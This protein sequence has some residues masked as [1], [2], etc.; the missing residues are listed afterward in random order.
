MF[1][2][3]SLL[4]LSPLAIV[5][6]A[7]ALFRQVSRLSLPEPGGVMTCSIRE[8]IGPLNPLASMGGVTRE[9]R[10]LV[11]EPLLVRDDDL[12]LRPNILSEWTEQTVVTVRCASEESAGETEAK[13][14]SGEVLPEDTR[15]LA[16]DRDGKVLTVAL[17]GF[18]SGLV[19][20]LL[21]RIGDEHLGRYLLV[22]VHLN[23][24]AADSIGSFL[25][26]SVER[27]QVKMMDFDGDQVA[28][29]FLQGDTDL[30]LRELEL[31]YE[32]NRSLDPEIRIVGNRCHTFSRELSLRLR[33]DVR[34]HDGVPVTTRDLLFSYEELTRP[35]SPLPL[36]GS[37][38]FVDTIEAVDDVRVRVACRDPA[39]VM[40]ESWEKL[41]LLPAHLLRG[42][43]DPAAW[44]GFFEK[45][46]GCG[47]YR[48]ERRTDDGGIELRVHERYFRPRPLQERVRY[49][50]FESLESKLLA[51]RSGRIDLLVPDFR[52]RE[53]SERNP[54]MVR[55]LRCLPR[56]Q[57]LVAWNLDRAPLNS[58]EV[59]RALAEAIDLDAVLR[60]T[61]TGFQQPVES[62]FFPGTPFSKAPMPLPLY[63]PRSAERRLEDAGYRFDETRGARVGEDGQPFTLELVVN[64]AN[65]EQI[66]LAHELAE[67]WSAVGIVV[68][69]EMLSWGEI[70]ASR[71]VSRDFDAV[72]LS[73]E[74]PLERDRRGAFHSGGAGPGE[75]GTNLFGLRDRDVDALLDKLRYE[76]DAEA[77]AE[78]AGR[79]QE[80][81]A[82]LQPCFF[83]CDTGR[84]I[85]MREGAVEMARPQANGGATHSPPVVGKAGLERS[86]PW[87]VR[88]EGE[89]PS[90]ETEPA[91]AGDPA[92]A[93]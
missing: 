8:P 17:E 56:F 86:R 33:S 20:E 85:W 15:L 49:R 77:I 78:A 11:F 91:G 4:Y 25:N 13:L 9:V 66:R 3:R 10:D 12:E 53:W 71:L 14:R 2:L 37:F 70:L 62:L 18:G 90:E 29:L 31:Y 41:P 63:A 58:R 47:P 32:S 82:A 38:W 7:T 26:R 5:F 60:D 48:V 19:E 30:F 6:G 88:R 27:G 40:M 24:S 45:P 67:Q 46:I 61:S 89:A 57:Q 39:P 68:E 44:D 55:Q 43:S 64:E 79:L 74:V 23:H 73:W 72:L 51:L 75:S 92:T 65:E 54:G 16:V 50:E 21:E 81:I 42:K 1:W 80:A 36:A 35:G 34:W 87:W 84:I 93:P 69:V 28:Q 59:R 52:F 83:I 76:D 22:E